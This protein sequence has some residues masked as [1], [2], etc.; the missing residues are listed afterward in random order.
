MTHRYRRT[1][2]TV[3]FLLF[4]VKVSWDH[5]M[6]EEKLLVFVIYQ[7]V[8]NCGKVDIIKKMKVHAC[9]YSISSLENIMTE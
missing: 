6:V 1:V 7:V 4:S 3:K 8:D 2:V 9:F 5:M